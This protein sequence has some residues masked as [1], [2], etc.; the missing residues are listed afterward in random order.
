MY[1]LLFTVSRPSP[2]STPFAV[3]F[4][5]VPPSNSGGHAGGGEADGGGSGIGIGRRIEMAGVSTR[6]SPVP[7][8]ASSATAS[9]VEVDFAMAPAT[10]ATATLMEA[11]TA[12]E[13]A[14]A[15]TA[16]ELRMSSEPDPTRIPREM[17]SAPVPPSQG[18]SEA[19]ATPAMTKPIDE[20]ADSP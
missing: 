11:D 14:S 6:S 18:V 4:A 2:S 8:P 12:T 10:P 3:D 13:C 5:L 17:A 1:P 15:V 9:A 19:S 16:P 20:V 7:T